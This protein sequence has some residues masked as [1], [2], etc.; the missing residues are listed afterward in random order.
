M[1]LSSVAALVALFCAADLPPV[2]T[3]PRSAAT[4]A[5]S[6]QLVERAG[7]AQREEKPDEATALLRQAIA[8]EPANHHAR[9]KLAAHLLERHPDE[10]LAILTELRDARCRA[11]L[12]AVTDFL[13]RDSTD[14]AT[15]RRRLE[16]LAEAAH[17]RPSR[18]SRAA[19]AIWKAFE[20]EDWKLLASYLG[21]EIRIKT[22]NTA[23]DDAGG[24]VSWET[25]SPA[26]M[27]SWFKTQIGLDLHR[28]ETWFCTERCC[29]YWSWNKS[30]NDV[31][32]YLEKI[33]FDTKSARPILKRLEWESG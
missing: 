3:H 20:R 17:G 6:R 25:L 21:D 27:R 10:A 5:A 24:A 29:D 32:N 2:T 12:R 31:T 22:L 7:A 11:C 1:T 4:A 13:E 16:A 30:R 23:V 9:V 33:C 8:A 18:V 19:D 14:D 26:Q 15:V 28:D